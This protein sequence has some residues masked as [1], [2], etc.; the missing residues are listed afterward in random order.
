MDIM[1][2]KMKSEIYSKAVSISNL[3]ANE[4]YKMP[5]TILEPTGMN[6]VSSSGINPDGS[7]EQEKVVEKEG[8]LILLKKRLSDLLEINL[9]LKTDFYKLSSLIYPDNI[10]D[11]GKE[12]PER[13]LSV[14]DIEQ[15][16]SACHVAEYNP[17]NWTGNN[18]A[19][20]FTQTEIDA[21]IKHVSSELLE[22]KTML[23]SFQL[24]E[25]YTN[26]E[27]Y[28]YHIQPNDLL[29]L[30]FKSD[31]KDLYQ[32]TILQYTI[33]NYYTE[34]FKNISNDDLPRATDLLKEYASCFGDNVERTINNIDKFLYD[35]TFYTNNLEKQFQNTEQVDEYF[36]K[37]DNNQ[38]NIYGYNF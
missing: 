35:L 13:P 24:P 1:M 17:I 9:H 18:I 22:M 23:D 28:G 10:Y 2:G 21:Y 16:L 37:N 4:N 36:E 14:Y 30:L 29:N 27:A 38:E 26:S 3:T 8:A 12:K 15:T 6:L 32:G 25:H 19:T 11:D 7:V 34:S 20:N 33:E 5:N 31:I